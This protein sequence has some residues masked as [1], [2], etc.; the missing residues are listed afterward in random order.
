MLR[1]SRWAW[2]TL[3]LLASLP[4]AAQQS[5][6]ESRAALR[7]VERGVWVGTSFGAVVFFDLP[8]TDDSGL[9]A[10]SIIGIE[11]GVD[12]GQRLQLGLMGWGA[13][14]GAP[15]GFSNLS[16]P[17][18]SAASG[19]FH[20]LLWGATLRWAFLSFADRYGVERTFLS[21]RV[22]GG[23]TLSRPEGV[24]DA[25]G[26]FGLA[27]IGVEYFTK[28]RRFSLG[29]EADWIGLFGGAQPLHGLSVLPH[30][31]YTF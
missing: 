3:V 23:G 24:L 29:V 5:V 10:G 28:L 7:E 13:S 12:L 17:G 1:I 27:G 19:D 25:S 9:G 15:V 21:A 4:A 11:A 31:K 20:S 14:V 8:A 30:L 6:G 26:A 22:G 2:A 18:A 16:E